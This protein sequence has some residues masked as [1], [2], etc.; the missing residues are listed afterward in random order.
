LVPLTGTGSSV[1]S[2]PVEE[3]GGVI[4]PRTDAFVHG[5]DLEHLDVSAVRLYA[6]GRLAS[7]GTGAACLGSVCATFSSRDQ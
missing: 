2:P 5:A 3:S 4:Q 6:D 7:E 1:A